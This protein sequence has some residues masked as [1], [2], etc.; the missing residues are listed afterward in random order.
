[1]KRLKKTLVVRVAMAI[2][3]GLNSQLVYPQRKRLLRLAKQV[4]LPHRL[5]QKLCLKMQHLKELLIWTRQL[6]MM[7]NLKWNRKIYTKNKANN[8]KLLRHFLFKRKLLAMVQA[9]IYKSY[10]KIFSKNPKISYIV[11]ILISKIE[12]INPTILK[13]IEH[14]Q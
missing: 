7:M 1:M 2:P 14:L 3:K 5:Y 10:L 4:D 8:S 9:I 12:L 6:S 11:P 13:I